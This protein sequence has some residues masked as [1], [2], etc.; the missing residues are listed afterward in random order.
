MNTAKVKKVEGI[1]KGQVHNSSYVVPSTGLMRVESTIER[2][3]YD[4]LQTQREQLQVSQKVLESLTALLEI[5][6]PPEK[7][8]KKRK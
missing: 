5:S 3:L 2:L 4:I 8:K 6:K 1:A 7:T